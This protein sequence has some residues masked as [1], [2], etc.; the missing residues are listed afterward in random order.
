MLFW[1]IAS[2]IVL[3][4]VVFL[5]WVFQR[6]LHLNPEEENMRL[7]RN[8]ELYQQRMRRAAQE[9]KKAY[10]SEADY[11]AQELE[12]GKRLLRDVAQLQLA[13]KQSVDRKKWLLLLAVAPFFAFT[14]YSSLGAW[15]DWQIT[16]QLQ[17][18]SQS[19]SM[20]QF[21][22]RVVKLH[23]ALE[24]RIEQK[25]DSLSYRM[26]L[27]DY[28][29][30]KNDYA[31]AAAHYGVVAELLPEDDEAWAR[32]AQAEFLRNERVLNANVAQA[33]DNALQINPFNPTVLGLQGIQAAE[34]GDY[35]AAVTAWQRLLSTMPEGSEEAN[36]IRQGIKTLSEQHGVS[37]EAE[38]E[39]S[40]RG[41]VEVN[42]DLSNE[43]ANLDPHLTV[44]VYARAESGPAA[45]LAAERLQ[46]KDL[47]V[48]VRLDDSKAMLEQFRLS[49]HENVV[50]GAR[51]SFSGDAMP[52]EGDI[53]VESEP[54]NWRAAQSVQLHLQ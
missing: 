13:G 37:V 50:I 2:S 18:L 45:P 32:Y 19:E 40:S 5:I 31:V 9:L 34:S 3:I 38:S 26:L 47:P 41:S 6:E 48:S 44:F 42:V 36:I 52:Q 11:Q 23:Q 14:L 8:V 4:A 53:R 16:Q 17:Q 22:Q 10:I 15:Q 29:M 51:I 28:A 35:Q 21:E 7:K 43:L 1:F 24:R 46:L 33:M 20:E 27:A 30:N 54:L 39:S 12:Y 49:L 25:P